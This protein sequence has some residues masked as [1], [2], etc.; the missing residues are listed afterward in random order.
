MWWR[1]PA[2]RV[3]GCYWARLT[4]FWAY[5]PHFDAIPGHFCHEIATA[6]HKSTEKGNL[7]TEKGNSSRTDCGLPSAAAVAGAT[8]ASAPRRR[9]IDA[10]PADLRQQKTPKVAYSRALQ[11]GRRR[12]FPVWIAEERRPPPQS[13][14]ADTFGVATARGV[15]AGGEDRA[16][17]S[18]K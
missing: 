13:T 3:P 7:C 18:Y 2:L 16:T 4:P 11:P 14:N 9:K 8:V 5:F 6:S 10:L 12:R 1:V 15:G 17:S